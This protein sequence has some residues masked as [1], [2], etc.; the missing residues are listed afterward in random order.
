MIYKITVAVVL[1]LLLA[2][3]APAQHEL[4]KK[5]VEGNRFSPQAWN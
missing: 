2:P 4:E 3:T 5:D 1:M